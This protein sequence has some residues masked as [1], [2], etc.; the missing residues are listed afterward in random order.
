MVIFFLRVGLIT[1]VQQDYL[2]SMVN[3]KL[4][5]VCMTNVKYRRAK[6]TAVTLGVHLQYLTEL[7]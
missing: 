4:S 1:T 5:S 6:C 2:F 7:T 3:V